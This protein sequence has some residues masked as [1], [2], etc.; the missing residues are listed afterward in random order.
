M[1]HTNS[2]LNMQMH[3]CSPSS[4]FKS[5]ASHNLQIQHQQPLHNTS[6]HK[7]SISQL[8]VG[9]FD[10]FFHHYLSV[11]KVRDVGVQYYVFWWLATRSFFAVLFCF[12]RLEY[13]KILKWPY[14][15]YPWTDLTRSFIIICLYE[16]SRGYMKLISSPN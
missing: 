8:P 16:M 12:L 5:V 10:P 2:Y 3:V 4:I 11:L 9:G 15:S 6:N 7:P 1:Y 13:P 14:L